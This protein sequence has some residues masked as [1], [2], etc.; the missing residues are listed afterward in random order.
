MYVHTQ[1]I[2]KIRSLWLHALL[3]IIMP[4]KVGIK[5]CRCARKYVLLVPQLICKSPLHS[6]I[7]FHLSCN[8][9]ELSLDIP[10]T[11]KKLQQITELRSH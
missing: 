2:Y 3:L 10:K 9:L 11:E 5:S 4:T 1:L 7:A 6:N 8:H